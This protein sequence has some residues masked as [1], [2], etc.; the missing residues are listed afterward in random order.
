MKTAE[1]LGLKNFDV[2]FNRDNVLEEIIRY[3][4]HAVI[5]YI[6]AGYITTQTE[7][8]KGTI[9]LICEIEQNAKMGFCPKQPGNLPRSTIQDSVQ[10]SEPVPMSPSASRFPLQMS[11]VPVHRT[12]KCSQARHGDRFTVSIKIQDNEPVPVSLSKFYVV[13]LIIR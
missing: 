3:I 13:E 10:D 5:F 1:R 7:S 11:T 8:L 2:S 4:I 12:G 9:I 6:F